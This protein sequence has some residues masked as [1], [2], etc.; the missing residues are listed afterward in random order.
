MTTDKIRAK[1]FSMTD[2]DYRDFNARL[3]PTVDKET[4]LGIRTPALRAFAKELYKSGGYEAFLADLPH[5]YFEENNLHAFLIE[6]IK[7]FDECIAALE[8][9]LPYVDN[10]ATCDCMRPKVLKKHP[11]SLEIKVYQWLKSDKPY[12]V[13][14][15]IG[16][17]MCY[18]LEEN[19]KEKH[20]ADVAKLQSDEY[21][22]NMMIAWYFATALAKQYEKT[23]PY[24]EDRRLPE[25]VHKKT[26]QKAIESYRITPEQKEY[27]R[28]LR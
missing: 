4:V 2:G 13:R 26:I 6:Q 18:Y 24:L 9:F 20:L 8:R 5:R 15:A 10:W 3:I 7:D 16:C 28:T 1:L 11:E 23:I 27:L 22:I 21:Y 12:T 17:L 14:Y 25:W 19:F